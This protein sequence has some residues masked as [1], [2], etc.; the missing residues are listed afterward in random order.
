MNDNDTVINDLKKTV[1]ILLMKESGGNS[2][3][4]KIYPCQ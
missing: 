1:K 3:I 4:Q 2:I